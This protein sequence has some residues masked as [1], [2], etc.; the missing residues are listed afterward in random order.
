LRTLS[1]TVV[2]RNLS[3]LLD[4]LEHGG[5]EIVVIR[6]KHPIA[7]LVPGAPRMTAIEA[8]GDVY[9]TISDA[10]GD[11]WLADSREGDRLLVAETRDPW[12]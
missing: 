5:E 2:A 1:A 10:E 8:L 7:K 3:R 6:N 4:S 12:A 9:A 11:T